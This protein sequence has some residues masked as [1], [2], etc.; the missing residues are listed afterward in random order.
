MD[1]NSLDDNSGY[2]GSSV[3]G[4]GDL[5]AGSSVFGDVEDADLERAS[6]FA[7]VDTEGLP[8][9]AIESPSNSVFGDVAEDAGP[10]DNSPVV[11]DRF[12]SKKSEETSS[13]ESS[14]ESEESSET[15]QVAL[16]LTDDAVS[17]PSDDASVEED[18]DELPVDDGTDDPIDLVGDPVTEIPEVSDEASA[19]STDFGNDI[20][21][22][23]AIAL[24][25]EP[26]DEDGLDAWSDLGT[27]SDLTSNEP[28]EEDADSANHLDT[29][30]ARN[31][32]ADEELG[33]PDAT[34]A[35]DWT[36]AHAA[37]PA[38]DESDV[39]RIGTDSERFFEFDAEAPENAPIDIDNGGSA[40]SELQSRVL[41]G[42]ALLAIAVIALSL[43]PIFALALIVI[44]VAI[45]AGEFYNA[46]R[47][48]G[49]QPAT[50]LGLTA[51]IAMPIAVYVRGTQ[52][53]ALVLA[54]T[55]VFGLIWYIAGVANEMP[56]MNLGVTL[57]GV[58]Y[59]GVL[60][61]FGA[62]LLETANRVPLEGVEADG[63]GLILAAVILTI[64]YDAGAF[65]AGR[66]MG[67]TPLTAISPNKTVEGLLG[68]F[69]MTIVVSVVFL[70][71]L[72]LI[73]PFSTLGSITDA[74]ILG[75]AAAVMAPLGD[76]GESLIKR[77][78]GIKDMGT[79]LPGHG[80][81]L[82]RFDALLFVLPTVYFL[83]LAFFF[84][85]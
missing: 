21:T 56:V 45:S 11:R 64:G 30:P 27:A 47:V 46:L 32:Q 74:L 69:F 76:L 63:T 43:G 34:A 61:S 52:A 65:F 54:L 84:G 73:E 25:V 16:D 71:I 80:G 55:V 39:V 1:N 42:V 66:S 20:T 62:A 4:D 67:R 15:E 75:A 23:E 2:S 44:V 38:D 17:K 82:D 10:V 79:I 57:L 3:F 37:Q 40:G 48:A 60:G 29:E 12:G 53:V 7:A 26:G 28:E 22:G 77:D 50:L 83:S 18:A 19:S 35:H 85:A 81:F 41:T 36:P 72:K 68:G 49:Y 8:T 51:S 33:D 24:D 31:A 14:E 5:P 59:I 78:L 9:E 58:V 6:V 13:E 70:S